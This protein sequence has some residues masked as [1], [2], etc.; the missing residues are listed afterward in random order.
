MHKS[1]GNAR[2]WFLQSAFIETLHDDSLVCYS[3][4][5]NLKVLMK[6]VFTQ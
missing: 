1:I 4:K 6:T 2:K 5:L 3:E